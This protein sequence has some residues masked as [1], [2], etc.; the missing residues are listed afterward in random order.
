MTFLFKIN[1]F[2]HRRNWRK[3]NP[4]NETILEG[5]YP[6]KLISVG[7]FSYGYINISYWGEE[8]EGLVIGHFVSIAAN[9]KFIL[10]G[11]HKS[12]LTSTFPFQKI[13][14]K[15]PHVSYSNGR[16]IV[17]D[18]VWIGMDAIVLSG[19]RIGQGAVIAAGSVVVNDVEPYA[20]IGGNPAKL[21]RKRF[22]P[23]VIEALLRIDYSKVDSRIITENI[24]E[25]GSKVTID[26][27]QLLTTRLP[28]KEVE[29]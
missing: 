5:I 8:N 23:D 25:L 29:K 7:N 18:D 9:V 6:F 12:D 14:D 20:I 10:G 15:F 2:F 16:I 24:K 4:H 19:V 13:T 27:I 21:I 3:L 28:K 17:E 22:S 11:N 1:R 26:N